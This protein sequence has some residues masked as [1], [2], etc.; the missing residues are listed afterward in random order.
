MN[1]QTQKSVSMADTHGDSRV[2]VSSH[3]LV[4]Q[5]QASIEVVRHFIS[6]SQR[7][8]MC[9]QCRGEEGDFFLQKFIDLRNLIESMP[10]TRQTDGQGDE[11]IAHLHYFCGGSDWYITEKDI[12][13]GVYQAFGFAVLNGDTDCAEY[14]YISILELVSH[15]VELDLY[16]TP[17]SMAEIKAK[18]GIKVIVSDSGEHD[19][20]KPWVVVENPGCDD[21]RIVADFSSFKEAMAMAHAGQVSGDVMRRL[22]DGSLTTEF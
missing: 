9:N 11:A 16:F 10:T 20:A 1:A 2:H 21:Q 6:M 4:K 5:A 14:G 18:H 7:A 8:V 22:P 12:E 17:V 3:E 15:R 19:D 13:G